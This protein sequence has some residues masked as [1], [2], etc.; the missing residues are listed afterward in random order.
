M[1]T[2]LVEAMGF[3]EGIEP[4]AGDCRFRIRAPALTQGTRM[5]DSIAIN[6]CCL[7]VISVTPDHF[8][9]HAV[10]ETLARTTL[11]RLQV[12]DRVNLERALRLD[13]RLGGHLV[14]GHVDGI[15][16]VVSVT[17]EGGG[18]RVVVEIPGNLARFVAEKGSIAIDG[19]S[20]TVAAAR[21]RRCEIALIPHTLAV[22]TA[23]DYQAGRAVNIEVD[24]MARYVARLMEEAGIERRSS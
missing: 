11:G 4:K 20:L 2:G 8:D 23:G 3:V 22:T 12:A 17:P 1:F 13:E 15:G 5:G 21:E 9:F 18:R 7:T 6:G 10:P 24:L 14:Q 19:I 16:E